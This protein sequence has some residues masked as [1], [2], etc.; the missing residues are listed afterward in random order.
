M[1]RA[2]LDG[3]ALL[4][5]ILLELPDPPW[6][7]GE[8]FV[9]LVYVDAQAGLS[10]KGWRA[11]APLDDRLTVRLPIGVPGR[12]LAD[13]EV[14]ARGLPA[15]PDWLEAYGPQPP[16]DAPWRHD[17]ALIGRLHR[18]FP[19]DL[20]VLVHEGE[21]RRT[22]RKAELCW[23]RLDGTDDGAPRPVTDRPAQTRLYRA[24]LLSAPHGL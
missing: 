2:T 5:W 14:A 4:R 8:P 3:R 7:G 16:L 23:V 21:P 10:A 17:P 6:E 11:S 9:G 22:G 24:T 20:Q 19:D 15:A 18:S 12:V 1:T 13:D